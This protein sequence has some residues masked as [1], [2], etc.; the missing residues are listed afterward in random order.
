MI[1]PPML[2]PSTHTS[3]ATT[4]PAH[5]VPLWPSSW[6]VYPQDCKHPYMTWWRCTGPFS[7][8]LPNGLA[9]SFASKWRTGLQSTCAT[10]SGWHQLG[11]YMGWWQM[12]ALTSFKHE[13]WGHWQSVTF[14]LHS[15]ADT[16]DCIVSF[17]TP[18]HRSPCTI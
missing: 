4:S 9:L 2:P 13:E 6:P 18:P 8:S 15:Y 16:L 12:Q 7:P 14:R 11:A 5:G 10:V 1:P 17:F 3:K